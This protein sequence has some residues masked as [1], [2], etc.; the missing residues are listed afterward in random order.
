MRKSEAERNRKRGKRQENV[1]CVW[2]VIP[3]TKNLLP[4]SAYRY[5]P[6]RVILGIA[7]TSVLRLAA[8]ASALRNFVRVK[9]KWG[10]VEFK[11]DRRGTSHRKESLKKE[12]FEEKLR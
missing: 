8:S 9:R 4:S 7:P 6:V 5:L 3:F 2:Y 12:S 10:V 11:V 1:P